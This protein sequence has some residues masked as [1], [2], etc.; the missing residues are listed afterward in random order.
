MQAQ[1]ELGKINDM[2]PVRCLIKARC[3]ATKDST[4]RKCRYNL[5]KEEEDGNIAK[6]SKR[7]DKK[8]LP[9][10]NNGSK[11]H[12]VDN[13]GKDRDGSKPVG[14]KQLDNRRGK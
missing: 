10:N 6:D 14:K 9:K 2:L 1:L 5:N 13:P 3:G 11:K 8:K 7:A 12:N 4:C